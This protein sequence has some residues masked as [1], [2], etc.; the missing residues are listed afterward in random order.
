M[1][2]DSAE[3]RFSFRTRALDYLWAALPMVTTEGDSFAE[4]VER[5]GLGLCVPAEDPV[6]LEAA[7][8]RL[9]SDRAL[10]E[11]CRARAAAVRERFRWSVVLG[12]LAQFCRQPRRAPDAHLPVHPLAPMPGEPGETV[13]GDTVPGEK[14]TGDTVPG[15]TVTGETVPGETEEAGDP[16]PEAAAAAPTDQ[17]EPVAPGAGAVV[18]TPGRGFIE[19]ARHHYR[20][21]GLVQV[22]KRAADK[23]GRMAKGD[24]SSAQ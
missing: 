5:E 12:P 11:E 15:E 6:A 13:P 21:G 20:E 4:L 17:A 7:L 1:H 9:L 16:G 24:K 10:A 8:A 23:A 14:V 22:A 18:G 2:F 19:L 3:T